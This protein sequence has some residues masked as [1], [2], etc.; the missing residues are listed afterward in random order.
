MDSLE[1]AQL[2]GSPITQATGCRV[3]AHVFTWAGTDAPADPLLRCH[4]GMFSWGEW[5]DAR[6]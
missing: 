2:E 1:A 5:E 3:G 6:E 4:C